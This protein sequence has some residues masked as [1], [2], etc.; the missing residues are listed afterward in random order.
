M[1]ANKKPKIIK[2]LIKITAGLLS[3]LL[4]FASLFSLPYSLKPVLA[5]SMPALVEE[6]P[7]VET[8]GEPSEYGFIDPGYR[9][10]TSE[11]KEQ[12]DLFLMTASS[13]PSAYSL[14]EVSGIFPELSDHGFVI[15]EENCVTPVR[16]QGSNGLCWVFAPLAAAESALL[17]SGIETDASALDLSELQAAY[18][19]QFRTE[20]SNPEGCEGDTVTL[21]NPSS[22]GS[23]GGNDFIFLSSAARRVGI[24][25]EADVPYSQLTTGLSEELQN[26][27][28]ASSVNRY[29]VKNVD[30]LLGSETEAV[31]NLVM[32]RGAISCWVYYESSHYRSDTCALH[33]SFNEAPKD[34]DGKPTTNHEGAIVGWDD[35]YS[36]E[37]FRKDKDRPSSDG[38]WLVKNSW[39]TGV[40]RNGFYWVSYEDAPLCA[41][42]VFSYECLPAGDGSDHIYQHDGGIQNGYLTLKEQP[43]GVFISNIFTASSFEKLKEISFYSK[44][45][46]VHYEI[47]VVTGI[48][49]VDDVSTP[50]Q[51]RPLYGTAH[52]E[53][54]TEGDLTFAGYHTL[55]LASP[56][57]LRPGE[58]YSVIIHYMNPAGGKVSFAYERPMS[59]TAFKSSVASEKG[60]SYYSQNGTDWY[61]FNTYT[62]SSSTVPDGNIR[63]KA[64][65]DS[66]PLDEI[67]LAGADRYE[68]MAL[69]AEAAFPGGA[70]E[71]VIVTGQDFP[72]ALAAA[73]Y[74]GAKDI[75]LL[76][77]SRSVLKEPVRK[78]LAE[79]W[80]GRVK[81]V[82]F[83][84]G[85]F[86]DTVIKALKTECHVETIDDTTFNGADRYETAEKVCLKVLEEGLCPTD[87]C[88]VAT[89][90][91][92]ADA[93]AA[94]PWAC[95]YRIPVLLARNGQ[96]RDSTK[97]LIARFDT[98]FALGA[99]NVVS[100]EIFEGLP[101][102][103]VRLAGENR[104]ETAAAIA[105]CFVPADSGES[106]LPAH[107]AFLS[108]VTFAAGPDKNFPDA[109]CGAMLAGRL[110]DGNTTPGA[111]LL[112]GPSSID[113]A[114]TDYIRIYHPSDEAPLK[115]YFLGAVTE[116]A[117]A[118]LIDQIAEQCE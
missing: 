2:I 71:A 118:Q 74:T 21:S 32:E 48:P 96:V 65:T 111:I 95:Y 90:Q 115:A 109:L 108:Q 37:N 6:E 9:F 41:G 101:A 104:Y 40:N 53:A 86:S 61:D 3:G 55:E 106:V 52:P 102:D 68:T 25:D 30:V 66:L 13:L 38:A 70:E 54:V 77:T 81:K 46:S 99:E 49:S 29:L 112:V 107:E 89:G 67:R 45:A 8:D 63:I 91:K 103:V 44:E 14:T 51:R 56:V 60:E 10:G 93:L 105:S 23:V 62:S 7:E 59:N 94:S 39:G 17:R 84:G 69:I 100:Q 116:E 85:G 78:L 64:F 76:I 98:V 43:S 42:N 110:T 34:K 87:R 75:P 31:K 88:F 80:E 114:V 27:S 35:S 47:S 12:E 50:A 18:Y 92:P 57:V 5:A 83:I 28:L 4:C 15:P 117:E 113:P 24:A 16:S 20:A 97:D 36:K 73:C 19:G 26:G 79:T 33:W 82:T 72:D 11:S 58:N 22:F 1:I